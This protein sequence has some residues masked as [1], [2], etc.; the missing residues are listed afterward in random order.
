MFLLII[1]WL[2]KQAVLPKQTVL[3]KRTV[4]NTP[5]SIR[6]GAGGETSVAVRFCVIGWLNVSVDIC[7]FCS[8]V[9]FCERKKGSLWE[10][11]LS[12]HT[13]TMFFFSQK[14]TEE[15][16]TQRPT[17]TLSQPISQNLTPTFSCNALWYLYA[18]GLLWARNLRKNALLTLWALWE[19]ELPK[20]SQASF[21]LQWVHSI[22]H[23]KTQ[24]NRTHKGL[25]RH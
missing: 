16:N 6:K 23:R 4:S 15:Q 17:E 3:L 12:T 14:N 2:L 24:M 11:K 13:P 20:N 5:L 7:V 10:K 8:S 1:T 25:Q 19:K 18:E 9:F 22:S 21:L